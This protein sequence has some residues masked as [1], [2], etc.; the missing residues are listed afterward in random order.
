MK[1]QSIYSVVKIVMTVVIALVSFLPAYRAL[2]WGP[3]RETYNWAT[4]APHRTMNSIVD[5]PAVGDERN[6]VRV[7]KVG[8]ERVVDEVAL[9][10]GQ[11]YE[12]QIYF[13]NNASESLNASGAGVADNVRMNTIL[14]GFVGKGTTVEI[15]GTITAGN[16]TP[17]AVWDEAYVTSTSDVYLRYVPDSATIHSNGSIDGMNIG[18][19]YLFSAEGALI[20]YSNNYWGVLPGCNQYAGFVSYKFVVDQ[21]GF[22]IAKEVRHEGKGDWVESLMVEPGDTLEFRIRY[23]NTGTTEQNN[24]LVN[25]NLPDA[26]KHVPNTTL[27]VNGSTP[28]GVYVSDNLFDTGLNIGRYQSG[29]EAVLTYKVQMPSEEALECGNNVFTNAVSVATGNGTM[30]DDV[31]ITVVRECVATELPI[32]GPEDVVLAVVAVLAVGVGGMY[33]YRSRKLVKA[34]ERAV[35]EGGV[36]G[37]G[38]I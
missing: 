21:P 16:T 11:E 31:E 12:V 2:A 13:H 38:K 29:S 33:W 18:P 1:K 34:A 17:A 7:R 8:D 5:N 10:V 35:G 15:S 27:L 4:A 19:D 3:E 23:K 14:P 25:D 30:D 28:G 20:G 22:E 9:E 24:V 26:L 36:D 6:F 32:T 37:N